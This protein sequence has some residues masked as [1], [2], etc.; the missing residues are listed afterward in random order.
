MARTLIVVRR[1][2]EDCSFSAF[3]GLGLGGE[4]GWH[5]RPAEPGVGEGDVD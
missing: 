2:K 3:F 5:V 4:D 1:C